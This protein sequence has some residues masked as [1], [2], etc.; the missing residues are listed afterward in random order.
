MLSL[1]LWPAVLDKS[2]IRGHLP[3]WLRLGMTPKRLTW[4]KGRW[5]RVWKRA[6]HSAHS[7][8]RLQVV[9]DDMS[10]QECQGIF[11]EAD[12]NYQGS[13]IIDIEMKAITHTLDHMDKLFGLG[14]PRQLE[15]AMWQP[16]GNWQVLLMRNWKWDKECNSNLQILTHNQQKHNQ[17]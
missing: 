14:C 5:R 10:V 15:Y 2:R 1:T 11:P 9:V 7:N 8:F 13:V 3:G 4:R 16:T 17:T 6:C 12:F